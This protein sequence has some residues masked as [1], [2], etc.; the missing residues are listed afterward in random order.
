M[1][2]GNNLSIWIPNVLYVELN[3]AINVLKM[4]RKK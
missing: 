4:F 2:K 1:L 3:V